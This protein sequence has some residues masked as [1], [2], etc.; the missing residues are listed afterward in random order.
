MKTGKSIVLCAMFIAV[1]VK[2][3]NNYH[4]Y[5]LEGQLCS[6]IQQ[7]SFAGGV[8]GAFGFFLNNNSSVDLRARE[9]YNF[10]SANVV[11]A[12]SVTYRY[13][14]NNGFYLGAGLGHH[15]EIS[16]ETYIHHPVESAMGI[17]KDIFH[18]SGFA[19]EMG[20]NFKPLRNS[21]FFSCIYPTANLTATFMSRDHGPN[22]LITA[23]FGIKIGMKKWN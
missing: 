9:I 18:R 15:H 17:E 1:T 2:A 12:I 23:N 5:Y 6:G 22:P 14:F 4:K 11:G 3:Q 16:S 21:G 8:G 10:S 20:Y 19:A 13:N 7:S